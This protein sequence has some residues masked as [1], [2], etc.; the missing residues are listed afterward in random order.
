MSRLKAIKELDPAPVM[1]GG[2]V[3][4][5]WRSRNHKFVLSDKVADPAHIAHAALLEVDSYTE[6]LDLV[7]RGHAIYMSDGGSEPVLV[8]PCQLRM[9]DRGDGPIDDLWIYTMPRPPFRLKALDED[10]E[11]VMAALA[12]ILGLIAQDG[13]AQALLSASGDLRISGMLRAAYASAFRTAPDRALTGEEFAQLEAVRAI[14]LVIGA[15]DDSQISPLHHTITCACLRHKIAA[16]D[17]AGVDLDQPFIKDLS[18]LAGMGHEAARASLAK[19]GI[20]A[21]NHGEI[22]GW[23]EKRREFAPLREGERP[24][25][26]ETMAAITALRTLPVQ[27]AFAQIRANH[28]MPYGHAYELCRAEDDIAQAIARRQDVSCDVLRRYA[29]SLGLCV[30]SFVDGFQLADALDVT[31]GAATLSA[32]GFA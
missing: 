24:R 19:A 25:H 29:Q 16:N 20:G 23:L 32:G 11:R 27:S 4:R 10:I 26:R 17:L 13:V 22:V 3:K 15:G 9:R 31:G 30:D 6:A 7:G 18:A 28:L 21:P 2:R 1:S 5:P 14:L 8:P 12:H